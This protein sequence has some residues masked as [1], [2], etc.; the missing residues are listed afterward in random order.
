MVIGATF[1]TTVILLVGE[2][3]QHSALHFRH[4]VY[5]DGIRQA[6]DWYMGNLCLLVIGYHLDICTSWFRRFEA[7]P[8]QA[9][10][11]LVNARDPCVP[12]FA[13]CAVELVDAFRSPC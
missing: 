6:Q 10:S 1:V 5:H 8:H 12:L 7:G 4:K 9:G 13:P 11:S 2:V 3:S